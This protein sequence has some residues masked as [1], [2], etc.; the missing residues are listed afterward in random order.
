MARRT[1]NKGASIPTFIELEQL[2]IEYDDDDSFKR[3]FMLFTCTTFIAPI[4]GLDGHYA[5]WH[6]H[7]D[8]LI[9]E[10]NWSKSFLQ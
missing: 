10:F 7:V 1:R 4:T 3:F 8:V 6:A 9:D 2:M 5:P